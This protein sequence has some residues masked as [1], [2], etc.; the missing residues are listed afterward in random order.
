LSFFSP[1]FF[2]MLSPVWS[3]LGN[4]T[5]L[6]LECV[7]NESPISLPLPVIT[8]RNLSGSPAYTKASAKRSALTGVSVAG[9][10]IIALPDAIAGP[11]LCATRLSGSL[12][13]VIAA[14]IPIGNL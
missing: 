1:A 6:I 4:D 7:I 8:D 10:T 3:L 12:N 5:I 14:I 11:I 2:A 9:L 13:G